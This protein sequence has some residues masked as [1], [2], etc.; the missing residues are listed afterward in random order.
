[1]RQS[2][3]SRTELFIVR[4]I[5]AALIVLSLLLMGAVADASGGK[6][7]TA[8]NGQRL[9][10]EERYEQAVRTFTCVIEEQPTDV[11][12]YRG[13]IEASL[14]LGRYASAVGDYARITAL[15]LPV[16][17]DAHQTILDGYA[18]RLAL[19]PRNIHALTGASFA[20]WWVFD[21]PPAIRLLN[22]LLVLQPDNVY[23][24]LLRGSSRLLSGTA[25][26]KGVA[27]LER[28]IALAPQN[29][30]VRF[31]VA[32][33]YTY[34]QPDPQRAFDEATLALEW[35]LDTPRIHAIL[36]NAYLAFGDE[37]A[38][39]AELKTHIEL[40]TRELVPAG[41]LAADAALTVD[42]VPGRSYEI[43]VP[44]NAGE[45]VLIN[46]S[47]DDFFDSILVLLAA[48][49]TPITGVDDYDSYFAGFEWV[50]TATATYRLQVTSFESVSTGKLTV[51]RD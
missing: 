38:A 37:Q 49:G 14:L 6:G 43:P 39:A 44:A 35:G 36:S 47:S 31:I 12:G 19:D 21:Y 26:V 7:C 29:A 34:G 10:D 17:P 4:S 24:N 8:A 11:E 28:G 16:H 33:A 2:I 1:M 41:P 42:L 50:A 20:H 45:T 27:D 30:H 40:V 3:A 5:F 13:R 48:D 25:K 46:T 9:I 18:A 51:T 22:R 23:G 32:D 15:V